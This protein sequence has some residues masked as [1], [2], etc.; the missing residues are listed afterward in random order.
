MRSNTLRLMRLVLNICATSIVVIA[1][2]GN[3]SLPVRAKTV[4]PLLPT[5]APVIFLV[6][7]VFLI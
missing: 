1:L 3:L 7:P 2:I 5:N 4:R 6:P